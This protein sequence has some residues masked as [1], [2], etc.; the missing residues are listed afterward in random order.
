MRFSKHYA[1]EAIAHCARIPLSG[2]TDLLVPAIDGKQQ[3]QQQIIRWCCNSNG[4]IEVTAVCG[5]RGVVPDNQIAVTVHIEN[6]S[7][8]AIEGIMLALV[9]NLY[10]YASGQH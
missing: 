7:G 4:S 6:N 2:R 10:F 5:M 1:L 3:V 8:K 9:E